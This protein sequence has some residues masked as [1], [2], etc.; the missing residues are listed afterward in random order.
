MYDN[1]I[2]RWHVIDPLTEKSRRW[3]PYNYAYNNP[4]SFID[5]DGM[6]SRN[7]DEAAAESMG[8]GSTDFSVMKMNGDI[9]VDVTQ[10]AGNGYDIQYT[11]GPTWH[12]R[13][14]SKNSSPRAMGQNQ[15][16]V[17]VPD[18]E[19]QTSESC[20]GPGPGDPKP[21]NTGTRS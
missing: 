11:N 18:C 2:G 9:N 4:I 12:K 1:Q 13:E 15:Q 8:L 5:P 17:V 14:S 6:D 7:A 21:K 16:D 10:G 20:N 19:D 3:T